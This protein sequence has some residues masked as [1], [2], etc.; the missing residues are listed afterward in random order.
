MIS[1]DAANGD[2]SPI[3]EN[4][5][6]VKLRFGLFDDSFNHKQHT[7]ENAPNWKILGL[8]R[9]R[10]APTGGEFAFF[11][12]VEQKKAL[13]PKGPYGVSFEEQA[14]LY[15]ISFMIGDAQPEFQKPD[16]IREAGKA[17]GYAFEVTRFESTADKSILEIK[18]VGIAPSYFDA[19]PSVNQTRADQSLKGLL[20][21]E[22]RAFRLQSGGEK[23]TLTI[24]S[25]RL[26]PGQTIEFKANLQ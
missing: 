19:Y 4:E 3:E 23:P 5:A 11:Q 1:V 16:R 8:N 22:M 26:V 12:N 20:P 7:K 6:L 10:T 14:S 24:E 17:I 9:W 18:N 15:H 2:W 13:A 21:G 25:D